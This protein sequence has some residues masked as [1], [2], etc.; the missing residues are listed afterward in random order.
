MKTEYYF[1]EI[2][3]DH[4]KGKK[5]FP[6]QLFIYNPVHKNYSLVLNGNRPLTKELEAFIDY[7]IDRGGK[8]SI[9]KKQKKTFLVAQ[10]TNEAEVPS[11]KT[12]ELHELEKERIMYIK[13][14]EMYEAKNGSFAFQSE[15]GKAVES[16]DFLSIIE[17]ARVEI[18]TFSVTN[19]YTVS[20]A[21]ELSKKHLIKDNFINRIVATCYHLTKT[22]NINDPE[23]LS[24]V[25]VGSFLM[26]LGYTQISFSSV[27]KPFI[28][29]FDE[30]KKMFKKHTILGQHLLKREQSPLS[31]RCKKIILDHHERYNGSGYPL[32]KFGESIDSLAL[33]VGAVAHIFEFSSGKITGNRQ[34]IKSVIFALKNKTFTPGLELD[35]GDKINTSIINLINTEKI[36]NN[37]TAA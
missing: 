22:L 12:R 24:D 30:E 10:E 36:D 32:E 29:M 2:T 19:S 4:L 14:R 23:A 5:T 15:F 11:L 21:I 9:L 20:F 1:F 25:I 34:S 6:F 18:L 31:D 37:K 3:K 28:T 8:L 7:L 35:F 26:H 16:D 27:K 33:L 17:R 13:L